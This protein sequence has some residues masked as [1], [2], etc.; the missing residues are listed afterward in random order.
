[1][2]EQGL[3]FETCSGTNTVYQLGEKEQVR[4]ALQAFRFCSHVRR[5]LGQRSLTLPEPEAL[6]DSEVFGNSKDAGAGCFLG[7]HAVSLHLMGRDKA[8]SVTHSPGQHWIQL[9]WK[10]LFTALLW[11]MTSSSDPACRASEKENAC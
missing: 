9:S 4:S 7:T 1:M 8:D 6:S 10:N 5:A 11:G 3:E 2:L